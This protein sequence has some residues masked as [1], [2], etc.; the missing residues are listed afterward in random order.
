MF[1]SIEGGTRKRKRCTAWVASFVSVM[2]YF[3][4][5]VV[6]RRIF[7]LFA[8]PLAVLKLRKYKNLNCIPST[9]ADNLGTNISVHDLFCM[10]ILSKYQAKVGGPT[11]PT[12]FYSTHNWELL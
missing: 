4:N 12:I 11:D 7:E 9:F 1:T 5:R 3:I 10:S 6:D 8:M 2:F